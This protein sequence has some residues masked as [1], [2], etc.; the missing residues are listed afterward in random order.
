MSR[1]I[2]VLSNINMDFVIRR[3]SAAE[4]ELAVYRGQGYGNELGAMLDPASPYREFEP[5]L[6]FLIMDLMELIEHD[7]ETDG[8]CMDRWFAMLEGAILP[9]RV[10]Y[11]SDAY[12]WGPEL[13]AVYDPFRKSRLEGMW[14]ERLEDF[15]ARHVNVHVL[16]YHR[17][18]ERMGEEAAFSMKMWYMGKILHSG[19]AQKRLA[20]LIAEKAGLEGRTPKKVLILDLDNTLWGGLAGENDHTPVELSEDHSGL[21]YKNLQRVI[22]QMQ[23]QGVLLAIASKNNEADAMELLAHHPHMVLRPACFAARRINWSRKPANILEI[24]AELN[25]GTDSFVFWD[26]SPEERHQVKTMLPEVE[27]PDFPDRPELLAPAM[28]D[29][30]HRFF[31]KTAVTGEDLVKTDQYAANAKRGDLLKTAADFDSYLKQLHISVIRE[32]PRAHVERLTQ[33]FNKTNQF[34]LTTLRFDQ[35]QVCRLLEAPEKRVYL[36]RVTDC[37]GDSGLAAAAVVDLAGEK[38]EIEEFVMSCRIMGRRIEYAIVTDMEEDLAAAGYEYLRGRYIPTAKNKPVEGLYE[39]LGYRTVC[40]RDGIREYEIFMKDRP[41]RVYYANIV[42]GSGIEGD[43]N[44]RKGYG[45][46]RRYFAGSGRD[47]NGADP[48]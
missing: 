9:E 21:A 20:E 25:L 8:A 38:P 23:R 17:L 5:E 43:F 28:V 2:A 44:E 48:G 31:E 34:N 42:T 36:Y 40:E 22:L 33:L 32:D 6:T 29:I 35:A 26:D 3:L 46:D 47:G 18:I 10:Y 19:E 27:V 45:N 37:F 11:V 39:E 30:Y 16:P 12:L 15:C 7:P 41:E 4:G 14:Q 13:D 24:A 1:K